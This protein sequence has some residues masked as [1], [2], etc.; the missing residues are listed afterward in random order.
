MKD[1][2]Q[3]KGSKTLRESEV[4]SR[5][6]FP[7]LAHCMAV[8]QSHSTLSRKH[9]AALNFHVLELSCDGDSP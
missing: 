9:Q 4:F 8:I 5:G 6:V 2:N 1:K 3:I 7:L